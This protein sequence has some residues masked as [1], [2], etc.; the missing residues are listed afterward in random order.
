MLWTEHAACVRG[1]PHSFADLLADVHVLVVHSLDKVI[2]LLAL[3]PKG[4]IVIAIEAA[5]GVLQEGKLLNARRDLPP[6][7]HDQSVHGVRV[8]GYRHIGK[9]MVEV[10]RV[11]GV[12]EAWSRHRHLFAPRAELPLVRITSTARVAQ[13]ARHEA[14]ILTISLVLNVVGWLREFVQSGVHCRYVVPLHEVLR[15]ELPIALGCVLLSPYKVQLREG[16]LFK[17]LR[18][19]TQGVQQSWS[20]Q[21]EVEPDDTKLN[22]QL[23]WLQTVLKLVEVL[24]LEEGRTHQLSL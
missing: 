11:F 23:H 14:D 10:S 18:T 17:L 12:E 22:L 2:N 13:R 6:G 8:D 21:I 5:L 20:V 3:P 19:S 16:I 15:K 24:A 1:L 9:E 7:H 4:L